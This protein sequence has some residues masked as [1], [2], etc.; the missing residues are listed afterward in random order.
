MA[1]GPQL[2]FW[3]TLWRERGAGYGGK[4]AEAAEAGDGPQLG[5]WGTLWRARGDGYDGK[6]PEAAGG[7]IVRIMLQM[8]LDASEFPGNG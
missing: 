5:Y 4:G 3:G 7:G 6:A 2:G 1:D 8:G